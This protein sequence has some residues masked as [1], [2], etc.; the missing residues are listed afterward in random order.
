MVDILPCSEERVYGVT[1]LD[2]LLFVL[3]ADC[4]DVYATT[5]QYAFLE[6]FNVLGLKGHEW[7]DLTSSAFYSCLYIADCAENMIRAVT[8][9]EMELIGSVFKW[10]V[11]ECPCGVSVTP[12][13]TLLVTCAN[14]RQ[15]LE[16]SLD[17]GD[18]LHR[19]ELS[20]DIQRPLHAVRLTTGH[21]VVSH[22]SA[23]G[24]SGQ[25]RVCVVDSTGNTLHAHGAEPGSRLEQLNWPCHM[26]T[27]MEEFVFV[28]DSS[29][30]RVKLL[31]PAMQLVREYTRC[32]THPR[33]L[34]LDR[35]SG[36]LYIGDFGGRVVIVQLNDYTP[37]R[38]SSV[39]LITKYSRS[40][41]CI[42]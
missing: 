28:A 35:A 26:T 30:K 10:K 42:A 8:L 29:N 4:I 33:R 2:D 5:S 13:N 37:F 31:S 9:R 3:R 16:L 18:W 34:H 22:S 25:H 39:R 36:R 38:C 27:S 40:A 14:N 11:P 21:Y 19:I 1:S 32:L 12:D 6:R 7:N 15:L 20:S 41:Q 23:R 17:N 24:L